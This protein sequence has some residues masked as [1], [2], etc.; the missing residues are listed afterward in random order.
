MGNI[1]KLTEAARR[2]LE[3]L[4]SRGIEYKYDIK[5]DCYSFGY[6]GRQS[7]LCSNG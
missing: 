2:S 1:P 7:N 4:D 6:Y 3:I 5:N